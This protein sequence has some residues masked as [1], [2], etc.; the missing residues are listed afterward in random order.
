MDNRGIKHGRRLIGD[1][2]FDPGKRQIGRD[3][4]ALNM[5]KLSYRLFSALAESAP[6]V[7]T[8]DEL[9]DRVWRGRAVSHDTI[10]QRVKLLREAL[11]DDAT[12]P[13]YIALVRG[14]GYRLLPEVGRYRRTLK[15][16]LAD[17]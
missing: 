10:T 11:G 4:R 9:V 1:L 14:E 7:V 6:N 5:P 15:T 2:V 12:A 13:R 3:G 8:H 17:L 16:S